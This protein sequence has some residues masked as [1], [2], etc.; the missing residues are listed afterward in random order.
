[1]STCFE[2]GANECACTADA[3]AAAERRGYERAITNLLDDDAYR[4]WHLNEVLGSDAKR[5]LEEFVGTRARQGVA[6][7]L[8]DTLTDTQ[9]TDR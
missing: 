5:A 4:R 2:C 8:T 7:Y 1:M 6:R 9:E 3:L